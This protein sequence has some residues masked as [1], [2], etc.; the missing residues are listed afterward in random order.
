M[1][2]SGPFQFPY[3]QPR[4][5]H[6]GCSQGF[7]IV[8]VVMV[9]LMLFIFLA[10][11]EFFEGR[12]YHESLIQEPKRKL[13]KY[14]APRDGLVTLTKGSAKIIHHD[15]QEDSIIMLSRKSC[16]GKTG[17]ILSVD[18]IEPERHFTIIS[19]NEEGVVEEEDCGEV[20]FVVH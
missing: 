20:Y 8:M 18:K 15:I 12:V 19:T 7:V 11:V 6:Q 10:Q 17:T 4:N 2:S 3:Q 5:T 16:Q 13:R 9:F 1:F 14:I